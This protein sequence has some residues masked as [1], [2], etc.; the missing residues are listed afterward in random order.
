[1]FTGLVEDV[2]RI[3]ALERQ[4][5]AVVLRIDSPGGSMLASEEIHREIGLLK[6]PRVGEHSGDD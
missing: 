2:G 4:T 1:M 3:A 5:D 6:V